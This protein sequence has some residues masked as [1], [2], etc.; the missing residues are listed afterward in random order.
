MAKRHDIF[1]DQ[2]S[3]FDLEITLYDDNGDLDQT[4]YTAAGKMKKHYTS[5]NSYSFN[6][7]VDAGVLSVNMTSLYTANLVPGRYVYDVEISVVEDD[8]TKRIIE[9]IA[10]VTPGVT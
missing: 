7:S 4:A 1:I 3:P 9:G 10:T 6:C 2:G 8:Y 5:T